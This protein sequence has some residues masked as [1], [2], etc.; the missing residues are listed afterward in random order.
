[1]VCY[2]YDIYAQ[3]HFGTGNCN[4]LEEYSVVKLNLV[5]A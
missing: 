1:M 5:V 4:I 2:L 3:S